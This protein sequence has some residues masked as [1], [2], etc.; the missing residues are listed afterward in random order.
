MFLLS[1]LNSVSKTGVS[2]A[3]DS[4]TFISTQRGVSE[5]VF[6]MLCDPGGKAF[7]MVVQLFCEEV[8]GRIPAQGYLSL[9][10]I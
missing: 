1:H 2:Q 6:I 10:L 3:G 7:L 5:C 9:G 4:G 8:P